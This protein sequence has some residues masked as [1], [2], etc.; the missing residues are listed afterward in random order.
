MVSLLAS[1]SFYL[2][3]SPVIIVLLSVAAV[4]AIGL[5]VT[6]AVL[7][8]K[9]HADTSYRPAMKALSSVLKADSTSSDDTLRQ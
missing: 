8:T 9:G 7:A 3:V 5:A 2:P 6:A 4:A 1:A